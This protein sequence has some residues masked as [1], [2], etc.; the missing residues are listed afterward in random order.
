LRTGALVCDGAE[1][2]APRT[3]SAKVKAKPNPMVLREIIGEYLLRKIDNP[4]WC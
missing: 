4:A 2:A 1:K 3:A